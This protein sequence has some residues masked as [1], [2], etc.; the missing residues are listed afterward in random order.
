MASLSPTV[1]P[2]RIPPGL[3]RSPDN[4]VATRS[5]TLQAARKVFL[6]ACSALQPQDWDGQETVLHA[7]NPGGWEV[8]S[9]LAVQHG[10]LGLVSR[11]LDWAH[12]RTGIP[13]PILDQARARRQGQ[14]VQMLVYRKAARRAAEALAAR[15]IRFVIF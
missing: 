5:A 8:V 3:E 7:V 1:L 11:S 12:Q 6:R 10:V 15:G 13:I 2:D 9:T 14:L 4:S